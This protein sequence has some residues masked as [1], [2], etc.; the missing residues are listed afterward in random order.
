MAVGEAPGANE[1]V[2]GVP[3]V[4]SA[5]D[6]FDQMLAEVGI[7]DRM[8]AGQP[9][10]A[11]YLRK[12]RAS[13]IFLTNVCKYRPPQ[14]K[15]EDF[16][17]DSKQTKPNQL[18]LEGL[19]ELKQ[20]IATV[21]PKLILALGNTALWALTGHRG[22]TKW[23][24]SMLQF[25][26]SLLMPTYHPALILREWSWRATA[27]HDLRRAVQALT[28]GS[29]PVL[30]RVF[31]V[32]PSF[33]DTIEVLNALIST[34]DHHADREHPVRI[35]SDLETRISRPKYIACHGIAWSA[36][37]CICIPSMCVER[38]EGYFTADQEVAIW[39]RE[40]HLL[41][42][43][44][45]EVVGQF[46]LYDA[47]HFARWKGYIPRLR[48]DTM[49]MQNVAYPGQPKGLDF[50]S[51]MYRRNHVYWKDESKEWNPKTQPE[52]RFWVYNCEDGI[53]TWESCGVLEQVLHQKQ[54]WEQYQF[55]MK[56]WWTM[57]RMMLRGIRVDELLRGMLAG[58]LVAAIDGRQNE[59][60]Y[61]LG[62]HLNINSP[63]Q[64]H[65]LFYTQLR[66]QIV[67]HRKTRQPTCD[68]D[69]LVL[70]AQREPLL[71]PIVER[72]ADLRSLSDMMSD[73]IKATLDDGRIRSSF[74]VAETYRLTSSKDAFGGGTNLQ[75]WTKG[76]EETEEEAKE[77]AL[78]K[79]A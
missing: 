29:W 36:E 10:D 28:A 55:Q 49:F 71:R 17:L 77:R 64:V 21:Q 35:A 34:A 9:V 51:S 33:P 16:F 3:F 46:F 23:R 12:Q 7:L 65:D 39:E 31:I 18:I 30:R 8:V 48:H 45:V 4:G 25:G 50:I 72:L 54:L 38:P 11:D 69:A 44:N 20:E 76:D 27:L 19:S 67:R 57:L 56:L 5:G 78:R 79:T 61:I 42:H 43:S 53:A 60:D 59:L 2:E 32:R 47:Q 41:T 26:R 24:G 62:Y 74:S 75:N 40:R 68:Q 13:R 73:I 22:I 70:F 63:K 66:C 37:E 52:E 6:E 58:E 1:E 14:N 15:I